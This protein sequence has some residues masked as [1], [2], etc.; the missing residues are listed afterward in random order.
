VENA[1]R[2]SG[3]AFSEASTDEVLLGIAPGKKQLLYLWD[4]AAITTRCALLGMGDGFM[5]G[6]DVA[7]VSVGVE[8]R[9]LAIKSG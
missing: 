8:S 1:N 5:P 4:I 9:N 6:D 2:T 3:Q 7:F